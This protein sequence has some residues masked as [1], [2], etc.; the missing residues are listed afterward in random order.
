MIF[1][2][3]GGT[4]LIKFQRTQKNSE[5]NIEGHWIISRIKSLKTSQLLEISNSA[6]VLCQGKINLEYE[7]VA[8]NTIEI[9]DF[10]DNGC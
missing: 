7:I 3:L 1:S 4:V 10:T 9:I 2:D 8:K 6:M 5:I